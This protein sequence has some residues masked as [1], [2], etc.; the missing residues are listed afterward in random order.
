MLRDAFGNA[1]QKRAAAALA[2]LLST[3]KPLSAQ[4]LVGLVQRDY[5]LGHVVDAIQQN[6][7]EL[8]KVGL[9]KELDKTRRR[10]LF[11]AVVPAGLVEVSAQE[12]DALCEWA[13][14]ALSG[15]AQADAL[16]R[17]GGVEPL[18]SNP[19]LRDELEPVKRSAFL[20]ATDGARPLPPMQGG[21]QLFHKR[22]I[23]PSHLMRD[24]F[25]SWV[26]YHY[27]PG[28]VGRAGMVKDLQLWE[29]RMFN[30]VSN[31][32]VG[33][34]NTNSAA[35]FLSTGFSDAADHVDI[36]HRHVYGHDVAKAVRYD[37]RVAVE[38]QKR[39]AKP[40]LKYFDPSVDHSGASWAEDDS[41]PWKPPQAT[42]AEILRD[43]SSS[44]DFDWPGGTREQ[45]E[46][47]MD[48]YLKLGDIALAP[49]TYS[50]S[51]LQSV[52]DEF[53][54]LPEPSAVTAGNGL[55]D[56]EYT[57]AMDI[58]PTT[59]DSTAIDSSGVGSSGV[60]S[61]GVDLMEIDDIDLPPP[62]PP[63]VVDRLEEEIEQTTG[64]LDRLRL[65]KPYAYV[66]GG[67]DAEVADVET[68]LGKLLVQD[69]SLLQKRI[70]TERGSQPNVARDPEGYERSRQRLKDL[71][72]T[73]EAART[74]SVVSGV[75]EALRGYEDLKHALGAEQKRLQERR[76]AIVS[77]ARI[78]GVFSRFNAGLRGG[79]RVL[80]NLN[81]A[82][83][84]QL[85]CYASI[86]EL[87]QQTQTG[88]QAGGQAGD[89]AAQADLGAYVNALHA[90]IEYLSSLHELPVEALQL[91]D[92]LSPG[93]LNRLFHDYE[94]PVIDQALRDVTEK[95]DLVAADEAEMR[96]QLSGQ[97]TGTSQPVEYTRA[98]EG[99][100]EQLVSRL[101]EMTPM[102]RAA[103]LERLHGNRQTLLTGKPELVRKLR[104]TLPPEVFAQTAA[105]LMVRR[106]GE[107][108]QPVTARHHAEA[109]LAR[110][111][112]NPEITERLLNKGVQVVLIP[113]NTA[114]TELE[115]FTHLAGTQIS[116]HHGSWNT[117]RGAGGTLLVAVGAEN[118]TGGTT[119][120][121]HAP[122]YDDGYSV[123]IHEFA[124]TIHNHG[125]T[126]D[127][128]RTI[129]QA[130]QH[131]W[132]KAMTGEHVQWPDGPTHG[133][134]PTQPN[135]SA[136]NVNEYFAQLATTYLGANTGHDPHTHQPR[137]NGKHH[138]QQ[139]EPPEIHALL[140][141][142][143]GTNPTPI[144]TNPI[145]Q[146]KAENDLW[147][148]F[149]DFQTTFADRTPT[150]S[151]TPSTTNSPKLRP[152]TNDNSNHTIANIAHL[153]LPGQKTPTN[154]DLNPTQK[155]PATPPALTTTATATRSPASL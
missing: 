94:L 33:R 85:A 115:E 101:P 16:A 30:H 139:H 141:H 113:E 27:P 84:T 43:A 110:M 107:I 140:Q 32:W 135:Y 61:G 22:H 31:V 17:I 154:N 20:A 124:H 147:K 122:H 47:Y 11:T 12:R 2:V 56:Y 62:P 129:N 45:F 24:A 99:Q 42:V 14:G 78:S 132:N 57:D 34:G 60:D 155:T 108:N 152:T 50:L 89:E 44:A 111:L 9:L 77:S 126:S 39:L 75:R 106:A 1:G 35:G 145:R 95:L 143:Y 131:K 58:D 28:H 67:Y 90:R 112:G 119:T 91:L 98:D 4:D 68:R 29:K 151:T 49:D 40:V 80:E 72:A 76:E 21:R 96:R 13:R 128:R 3:D 6:V 86:R 97:H 25:N 144:T 105:Q 82:Q 70:D 109:Q 51:D 74:A 79:R 116:P 38:T 41:H 69:D 15:R 100:W 103:A 71:D 81:Q 146:N 10:R 64:Q 150:N 66:A 130:F 153:R 138:V 102:E 87:N 149:R 123:L 127:D 121:G 55:L 118:L 19:K 37:P 88:G 125:L 93:Q 137:N 83:L 48:V 53:L 8:N 117:S 59:V 7:A 52:R 134:N 92:E 65:E 136:S 120:T 23:I 46:Q 18:D 148:N 26:N 133:T 5:R 114:L 73:R 142:V 104:D 36:A 54:A 63:V